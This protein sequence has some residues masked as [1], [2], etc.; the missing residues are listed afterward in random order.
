MTHPQLQSYADTIQQTFPLILV[1]GR[2]PNTELPIAGDHGLYD[3]DCYPRCGFWN[4]SYSTIGATVNLSA[5]ALKA[6]CRSQRGSPILYADAL[7][8]GLKHAIRDK[9]ELRQLIKPHA[10]QDHIKSIFAFAS[11]LDRVQVVIPSGLDGEVFKPACE[12]IHS[13]SAE[14]QLQVIELPFFFGN[15]APLIRAKLSAQNKHTLQTVMEPF[16]QLSQMQ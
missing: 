12:T 15:N 4:I 16:V 7:P 2:E 14:R 3:F 5:A 13:L 6:R 10:I 1:I 11:L 8:I 9:H